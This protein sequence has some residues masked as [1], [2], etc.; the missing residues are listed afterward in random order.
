MWIRI[1]KSRYA[2]GEAGRCASARAAFRHYTGGSVAA[3]G[4]LGMFLLFAVLLMVVSCK[5]DPEPAAPV[6]L[7]EVFE[8]VYGPGQHASLAQPLDTQYLTGN[9][10]HHDG[11]LY[12]GGYGGYV[13]AG[14]PR[15]IKNEEGP[16]FEVIAMK[17]AAPEPAVVFV[18]TDANGNGRPDDSWYELK[19]SLTDE[20]LR[21]YT[22]TYFKPAASTENIRWEDSE[23]GSGELKSF[24]GAAHSA[25]WWWPHST[26]GTVTFTGSRLPAI[27]ENNPAN[28][29]DFWSVPANRVQWGYAENN[30]GTDYDAS[31]G[32][33]WLDISNAVDA[34]GNP[35]QLASIRFLKIQ[36]AVFQQAGQTNEVSPEIRGARSKY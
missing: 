3:P 22:V 24:F 33:N 26:S 19:G 4:R 31:S 36:S 1:F 34:A 14:F 20:T 28:G 10:E 2:G 7:S 18:M 29:G 32:S 13:V 17:G 27:Y 9:P 25:G 6:Y 30:Q 5:P 8:Y 15:E 23:G 35:V 21:N 11:W 12:L 16:D